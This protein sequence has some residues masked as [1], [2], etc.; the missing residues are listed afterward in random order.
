MEK[1]EKRDH[2]AKKKTPNQEEDWAGR[3]NMN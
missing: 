1:E 3:S 2:K